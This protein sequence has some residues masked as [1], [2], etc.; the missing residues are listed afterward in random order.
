MINKKH[1]AALAL[2]L[3]GLLAA[4]LAAAEDGGANALLN[5]SFE[6][7]SGQ[8]PAVWTTTAWDAAPASAEFTLETDA[9]AC[10][11]GTSC[12]KLTNLKDN[13]ARYVQEIPVVPNAMYKLSAWIKAQHIDAGRKGASLSVEGKTVATPDIAGTDDGW[14]YVEMYAIT[15]DNASTLRLTLGLGGYGQLS[16]G[17]AWFDDAAVEPVNAVPPG[18]AIVY[19]PDDPPPLANAA[20]LPQPAAAA[21]NAEPSGW[22]RLSQGP[23][24]GLWVCLA[25]LLAVVA[26]AAVSYRRLSSSGPQPPHRPTRKGSRTHGQ[27]QR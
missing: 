8:G 18:A 23:R 14:H 7:R 19:L 27:P 11:S 1:I 17:E 2:G 16:T 15:R 5:A 24:T 21:A 10:H 3:Y 6:E 4:S 22:H 26:G 20:G 9:A 12:A 25:A 13:D